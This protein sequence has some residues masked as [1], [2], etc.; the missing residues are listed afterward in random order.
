MDHCFGALGRAGVSFFQFA[1]AF[2][3]M[4]LP[5][6]WVCITNTNLWTGMCVF[7]I[8]IGEFLDMFLLTSSL[9]LC[10]QGI[11]YLMSSGHCFLGSFQCQYYLSSPTETSSSHYAPLLSRIRCLCT[12][13]YQS[14]PML[15]H[16]HCLG[17]VSSSCRWCQKGV[18]SPENWRGMLQR[19]SISWVLRSCK[20]LGLSGELPN[21][22]L[23]R[24]STSF[25]TCKFCIRLSS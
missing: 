19:G 20:R 15:V 23:C 1:F 10:L 25:W 2:G 8:I 14:W 7:G 16:S 17:C 18:V 21:F 24:G 5:C 4:W 11:R 13:T 3:G 9:T 6:S 12:V 22:H